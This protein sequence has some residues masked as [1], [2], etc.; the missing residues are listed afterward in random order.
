[1]V[2]NCRGGS[3]AVYRPLKTWLRRR[4][5][6]IRTWLGLQRV[7]STA[8]RASGSLDTYSSSGP[9]CTSD[10]GTYLMTFV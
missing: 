4:H 8:V 1:M 3:R 10:R 6:E 2:S 5:A 9:P 7:T